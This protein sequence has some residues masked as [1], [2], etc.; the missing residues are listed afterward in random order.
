MD[1][2]QIEVSSGDPAGTA[3][4]DTPAHAVAAASAEPAGLGAA[5]STVAVGVAAAASGAPPRGEDE[6]GAGA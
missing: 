1:A 2:G 5:T 6:V 3:A 4:L